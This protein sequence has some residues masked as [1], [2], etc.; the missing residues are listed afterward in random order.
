[1]KNHSK[2]LG[3]EA[4]TVYTLLGLETFEVE[5]RGLQRCLWS[6]RHRCLSNSALVQGRF[7][8]KIPIALDAAFG[9]PIPNFTYFTKAGFSHLELALLL[10]TYWGLEANN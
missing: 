6:A 10:Q 7:V 2:P 5:L 4:C 8:G 3:L 9:Q 1:M